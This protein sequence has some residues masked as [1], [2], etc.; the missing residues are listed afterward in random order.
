MKQLKR[1]SLVQF[2]LHEAV[3]I[4]VAGATAFLGPN[5]SGKSS[6]LDAIQIAMLG[7]NQQYTRFNTQ[8]VSTKQRRSLTGYCLG[9]LRNPEKDSEVIGRARDEARTYIML[10]FGDDTET[11][12]V[13]AGICIEAD[14]ETDEHEV[15]GLFVLPGLALKAD[16]CIVYDGDDQRPIPFADFRENVREQA[17]NKGRT[18]I[19]TD[20]SSEYVQEL[21]YAL[22]GERMP[23]ARRFMS[24]FVKSMTL[25]NVDSIDQFVR[26]YVVESNPVDIATFRKQV[27]QFIAL[28]DLI[29]KTKARISRLEGIITDFDRARQAERRIA[30]L[31][32][33]KAIFNA[34]WLGEK[35]DDIET[36]IDTLQDQTKTAQG[37]AA[38]AKEQRD[39]K[40]E[41]ITQLKVRLES[42]QN[43]QLRQRL[44][45]QISSQH[46]IITAYQH[47]EISRANRLIT[48][49]REL[50]DEPVFSEIRSLMSTVVDE[51][52][53]A[54][55]NE[56]S[57]SALSESIGKLDGDLAQI[58]VFS[59][60]N[61]ALIQKKQNE[62]G[63]ERDAIRRRISAAA[64]TG[65]L[66]NDGAAR[67]LE[68]L[69]RAGMEAKPLSAL[70]RISDASWAPALEAYLGGDR[71]ALIITEGETREA[72]KLLRQARQ[73]GIQVNGAAIIQPFHLRNVDTS[74]KGEEFALG[75]F[76]TDDDT[77]RRFVWQKFGNMRLVDTELELETHPRAIT[78]DGMLSQ[79]GLTKSIRIAPISDLRIGKEVQDTSRLSRHVSELQGELEQLETQRKRVEGLEKALATNAND[80]DL[81]VTEK[82]AEANK[83]I[84]LAYQQ[85]KGLD[86]SHLDELRSLLSAAVSQHSEYDN[87]Y[88]KHDRL[89]AGLKEQIGQCGQRKEQLEQQLPASRQAEHEAVTNALVDKEW[90]DSMKDEI[91]RA[92]TSYDLRLK[93]VDRKLD[94]H[95][96]RLRKAEENA[97]LELARYVQD[98]RLDVQVPHMEWHERYAWTLEEKTKL[99][100]TELHRYAEEAEL[101]RQASE[102]TLRSDIAMSLHDRFKEMELERRER[103]K[104]LESCPSFT[105]GERY[106]FTAKVVPQYEALVRYI[107]QIAQEDTNFSLFA[108][109]PDEINETLRD[110]VEAAA[111]S[112]NASGVL[113]YRQFYT[114]DLDILVD[115]KRVDRMSN[116]QGAGSNGEHIAPMYVAAGAALAKAYRLHSNKGKQRGIGLICLDEA[117][118]GMDTINAIATAR[119]LQSIGLQL[120]MAGPELERTKLAP[121][122]QTIYDLD[123]EGLDLQMERTKFKEAAN[124]LMVSDMPDENPEVMKGAYQQLGLEQ[125]AEYAVSDNGGQ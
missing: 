29:M 104:I 115:G 48:S 97:S 22:N 120:I 25:K 74:A 13:S 67:L 44:E 64:Q 125:P 103:N 68:I 75:V 108:E 46:Q 36:Q 4:E 23:N 6:T 52:V 72:V 106:K 73:Q 58:R 28:R 105:G 85:L 20:K 54:R 63:E 50:I 101:A 7:G 5:G 9:M 122:T 78:R 76:E 83:V 30:T 65:R 121:V 99:F 94:Y 11:E 14:A 27:E 93:E 114:F 26:D 55:G 19:F 31:E 109:N 89:A 124:K 116:R 69:N 10:V 61:L 18:P 59:Q 88:T 102:E 42:D 110:L 81:G 91:E 87:Q 107:N 38:D 123:R 95:T 92:E 24:S 100:N 8:S 80:D 118:H 32:A 39:L 12:W 111:D 86:V 117:F 113:D 1:I 43:E 98:E 119:F 16:D 62:L 112:G 51:L 90:L 96:P 41:D 60:S 45:D 57:G 84:N 53:E 34:E 17:R 3:D 15:K 56:N 47:P 49:L 40:Q 33:I 82:L 79:G 21:L 35:I 70:L 71:D 2:Y 77:A 37:L 66:L